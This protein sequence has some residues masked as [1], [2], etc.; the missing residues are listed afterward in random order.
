MSLAAVDLQSGKEKVI[1]VAIKY[2]YSS[3]TA[4]NRAFQNVHDI[5]PSRIRD[6]GVAL[7]SYP[8]ICF[9]IQIKGKEEMKFKVTKR[10]NIRVL[11]VSTKLDSDV[12]KAY[13]QGEALWVKIFTENDGELSNEENCPTN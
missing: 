6:D 12:A 7:K 9:S 11:G 13:E 10:D 8:P 3:P 2:G 5:A 4:F 1:D